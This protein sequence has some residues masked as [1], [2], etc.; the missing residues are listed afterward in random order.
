M[1][2]DWYGL[3]AVDVVKL[4]RSNSIRGLNSDEVAFNRER[5]GSNGLIEISKKK[6][7][8]SALRE[9]IKPWI[10]LLIIASAMFAYLRKYDIFLLTIVFMFLDL[11]IVINTYY[12]KYREIKNIERLNYNFCSVLRGGKLI[13]I[14]AMELVVGD[15]I[16]FSKGDIIP[17]EVRIIDCDKLKINEVNITGDESIVEK[18]S[19]KIGGDDI[20]IS[21]MK[22]MLFK[23]SVVVSGEGEGIVVSVGMNTEFGRIMDSFFNGNNNRNF[24]TDRVKETVNAFTVIAFL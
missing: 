23:S 24:I 18:F 22:N 17:G 6:F 3:A 13:K 19:A 5:Y 20:P 8:F 14:P 2:A 9:M 7:I 16:I 12:K 4:F 10:M 1:I 21:E 15:I 11:A